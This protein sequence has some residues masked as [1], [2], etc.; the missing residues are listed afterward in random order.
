V[1]GAYRKVASGIFKLNDDW[2]EPI[3]PEELVPITRASHGE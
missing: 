1:K 2:D 3:T